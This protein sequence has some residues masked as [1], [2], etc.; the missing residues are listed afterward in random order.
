MQLRQKGVVMKDGWKVLLVV[1]ALGMAGLM[2][3][4]DAACYRCN[5]SKEC[6]EQCVQMSGNSSCW[7]QRY[8]PGNGSE[9]FNYSCST[10]GNS[11]TGESTSCEGG[12]SP[13]LDECTIDNQ[14]VNLVV[15][16]GG[17]PDGHLWFDRKRQELKTCG[18]STRNE[19]V[20]QPGDDYRAFKN[21]SIPKSSSELS[22]A[23]S[24]RAR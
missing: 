10:S 22:R 23:G 18:G 24:Q 21:R 1:S 20:D 12:C 15:P 16:N 3:S 17:V 4:A 6:V 7:S 5:S 2:E 14:G 19:T 11:C 8:C 9:C 13:A